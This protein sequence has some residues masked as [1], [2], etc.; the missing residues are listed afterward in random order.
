M[1]IW[2]SVYTSCG[3]TSWVECNSE[4]INF[5]AQLLLLLC[6]LLNVCLFPIRQQKL[7]SNC[8]TVATQDPTMPLSNSGQTGALRTFSFTRL[9]CKDTFLLINSGSFTACTSMN[10]QWGSKWRTRQELEWSKC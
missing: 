8:C 4:I 1:K 3:S 7:G 6:R 5:K 9:Q 10:I 2:D